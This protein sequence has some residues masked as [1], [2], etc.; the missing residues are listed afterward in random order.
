MADIVDAMWAVA[1]SIHPGAGYVRGQS[2]VAMDYRHSGAGIDW[3]YDALG[4]PAVLFE[5]RGD[6]QWDEGTLPELDFSIPEDEIRTNGEAVY[7]AFMVLFD[8]YIDK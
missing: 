5:V 3:A 8:Q 1:D 4:I 2:A 7:G 6:T